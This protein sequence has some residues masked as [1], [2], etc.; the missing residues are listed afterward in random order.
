MPFGVQNARLAPPAVGH[1]APRGVTSG[2]WCPA[3]L[4]CSPMKFTRAVLF[5]LT[6]AAVTA[7]H[8][9]YQWVDK[10]GRRVFSDRPPPADVAPKNIVSQP[11]GSTAAVVRSAPAAPANEPAAG[12]ASVAAKPAAPAASAA[13]GA[14][15]DKALEEK[16]KQAEAAEAAKKKAEEQKIAAAKADN[17][18]RAMNAKSSLDSGMRMARMNDKG[19]RE[20]LDDAQ[21]AAELKRVNAIIASDCK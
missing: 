6:F 5:G 4:H 21:R 7:A 10:D 18:K 9:Q 11:R 15:V 3:P 17:C 14:G 1:G 12:E 16:K 19:E 20:V 2:V 8:A 13:P